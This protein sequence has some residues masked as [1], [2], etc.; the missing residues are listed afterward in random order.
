LKWQANLR[1]LEVTE[2]KTVPYVPRSHPFVE[3]LIGSIRREYLDPMLFW[4]SADLE[5]KLL[6]FRTYFNHH[7]THHSRE[8]RTRVTTRRQSALVSLATT[9]S[10]PISHTHGRLSFQRCAIPAICRSPC[11]KTRNEIIRVGVLQFFSAARFVNLAVS[12]PQYQ[13][14]SHT[15]ADPNRR[16]ILALLRKGEKTAGDLAEQ[17]DMT[18][19]SMSHHFAVL[20]DADL[21]VNAG[22]DTLSRA[23]TSK[24]G[25]NAGE[26]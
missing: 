18:K 22:V 4:T 25:V 7:R 14:A 20:K 6:D 13:F 24:P 9:L 21:A 5:N 1:I 26:E 3:R 12:L 10:R 19:P 11:A 17:F 23:L 16:E 2:I 15:L 8:G